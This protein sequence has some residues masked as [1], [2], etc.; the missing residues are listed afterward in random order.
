VRDRPLR[1]ERELAPA[2]QDRIGDRDRIHVVLA[3]REP[4][5]QR[6]ELLFLGLIG[7]T[8]LGVGIRGRMPHPR[9]RF[10]TKYRPVIG[11]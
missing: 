4:L 2:T 6:T 3:P 9:A 11:K 1:E 8:F 5:A 10:S 7:H